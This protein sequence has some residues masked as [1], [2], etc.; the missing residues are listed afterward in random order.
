MK[1]RFI[2]KTSSV[3]ALW[4]ALLAIASPGLAQQVITGTVAD[5]SLFEFDVPANWNGSLVV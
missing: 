5:G 4:L 1:H 2:F 3:P